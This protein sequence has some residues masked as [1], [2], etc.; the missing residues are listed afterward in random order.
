MNR[1][2]VGFDGLASAYVWLERLAFGK[3]LENARFCH[4]DQLRGCQQVL[5]LGEGDG[6]FLARLVRQFPAMRIECMDASS[7]MLAKAEGRLSAEDRARV[8]FRQEDALLAEFGTDEYD[9]VVTL[10]F[11]DCFSAEEVAGLIGRIRTALRDDARWLWADFALPQRG[12]RRWRAQ[13]WLR[14]L[15]FFFRIQTAL[16][17]RQLPPSEVLLQAAGFVLCAEESFQAGLLRSAVWERGGKGLDQRLRSDPGSE[18]S[19]VV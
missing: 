1:P 8:N 17:A 3:D 5:V 19:S 9:A 6:R 11:L 4:L 14:G 16:T 10:F 13:T 12:W 18:A 2:L 7:A 15:Y